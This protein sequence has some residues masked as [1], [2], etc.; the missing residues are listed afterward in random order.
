MNARVFFFVGGEVGPWRV[1][2]ISTVVGDALADVKRLNI[3]AGAVP[4]VPEGAKWLL[5]D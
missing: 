4:Q 3:V 1:V 5:V 2:K